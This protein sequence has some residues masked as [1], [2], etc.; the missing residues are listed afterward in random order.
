MESEEK[1]EMKTESIYV[2]SLL[3]STVMYI[4]IPFLREETNIW[5]YK[6]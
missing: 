6:R 5:M 1:E 2:I 3:F 4:V